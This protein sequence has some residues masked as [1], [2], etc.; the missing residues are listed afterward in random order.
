[1]NNTH[2]GKGKEQITTEERTL[3]LGALALGAHNDAAENVDG[4]RLVRG[5]GRLH[6]LAVQR[7]IG[8]YFAF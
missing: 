6:E 4:A 7:G 3:D 1:M 5:A 2:K 8:Y